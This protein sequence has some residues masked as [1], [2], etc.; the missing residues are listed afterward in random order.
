MIIY[1]SIEEIT[2]P[3]HNPVVTIGN[4]DGVHLGHREMFRR[5][6]DSAREIGGV[7]VVVTF[8][9]HPLRVVASGKSVS[10]INTLEEKVKLI[11]ASGLDYLLIIPFDKVFAEVSATEFVEQ[12]LV[13]TIGIK[14][15]L[16]GY[17]YVFGKGRGGDINLLRQLGERL[18]FRVDLLDPIS[19]NGTIFSSSLI[20]TLVR[21]GKVGE[22]VRYLGRHF[23]LGGKVVHGLH[24]GKSLGFPTA[25]I[26]TDKELIPA[27]GVYAVKIRISNELYDGAC[28]IGNNPTFA[29][30]QQSIEAYIFDF[31]GELYGQ[32]I[33]IYFIERLREE[34]CFASPQ[35]LAQAIAEDVAKCRD[36][37]ATTPLVVYLNYLEGI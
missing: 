16:I 37:L 5:L 28:N 11:E 8:D 22:V 26:V 21:E 20:R 3:L 9:P 17:D 32:D 24:R 25:N 35:E 31:D 7:S 30:G 13:G 34:R 23:S 4:F 29:D 10:L 2:A 18:S 6:K 27:D 36:I 19:T 14:R 33:R 15:L 1:R 12:V